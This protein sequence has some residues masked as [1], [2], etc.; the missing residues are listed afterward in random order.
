MN[1]V[2]EAGTNYQDK[3]GQAAAELGHLAG[4]A[5]AQLQKANADFLQALQ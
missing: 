2:R 5:L 1:T 3:L 4:E